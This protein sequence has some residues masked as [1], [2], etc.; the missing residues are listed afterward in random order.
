[1]VGVKGSSPNMPMGSHDLRRRARAALEALR[2]ESGESVLLNVPDGGKFIVID[3]LESRHYLRSAP[4]VGITVPSNGSA[5]SRAILP[6]M[7]QEE[8][9]RG[10]APWWRP[11]RADCHVARRR[12]FT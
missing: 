12:S 10:S 2:D 4:P 9:I 3:V 7:T 1:M 6:F 11:L 8:Q 5:T